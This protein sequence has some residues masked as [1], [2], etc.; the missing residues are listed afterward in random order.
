MKMR[1]HKILLNN[2]CPTELKQKAG[3][4]LLKTSGISTISAAK[5]AI[6]AAFD[7]LKANASLIRASRK[8]SNHDYRVH[9]VEIN[10][11]GPT[12]SLNLTA[13]VAICSAILGKPIQSQMVILGSLSLGGN[14][15]PVQNIAESMQAAF[16]AGAKILL[17]PMSSVIDIPII[18]DELFAKFQTS[19][20]AYPIDGGFK[21]FVGVSLLLN[22]H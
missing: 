11:T 18:P 10:N 22:N 17:L 9:T 16:G 21:A 1:L 6:K 12:R 2:F 3:N 5:E 13:Y 14:I 20:Y 8:P 7:F 4:G 19:F 15:T